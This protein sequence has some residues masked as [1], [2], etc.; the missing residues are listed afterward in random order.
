MIDLPSAGSPPTA[1]AT[2]TEPDTSQAQLEQALIWDAHIAAT[3]PTMLA[4]TGRFFKLVRLCLIC[5]AAPIMKG[6]TLSGLCSSCLPLIS[7]NPV[8]CKWWLHHQW[9]PCLRYLHP[10]GHWG[11]HQHWWTSYQCYHLSS[12]P[13]SPPPADRACLQTPDLVNV[14]EQLIMV[15]EIRVDNHDDSRSSPELWAC[16]VQPEAPSGTVG[17]RH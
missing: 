5:S 1:P 4:R 17:N 3:A 12:R 16:A 8:S 15:G 9:S 7:C 10:P 2:G 11:R 6:F 13:S 14:G